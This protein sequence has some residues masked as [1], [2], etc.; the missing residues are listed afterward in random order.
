MLKIKGLLLVCFL[1]LVGSALAAC[2]SSQTDS[3]AS[4]SSSSGSSKEHYTFKLSEAQV[5]QY[6]TSVAEKAFAKE[7]SDKTN[8]RIQ[9]KVYTGGQLG[10]EKSSIEQTQS[11]VIAFGRANVG[12]MAQYAKKYGVFSFPF[13]FSSN[14]QLFDALN[15]NLG[16]ALAK[17]AEKANLVPLAYFDAGSRNFYTNK[18]IHSLS[19]LKGMKIR[20]MQNDILINSFKKLGVSPTPM[21]ASEVYSSLQTGVIDGAENNVNTYVASGAYE[22]SKYFTETG[23][24]RMPGVMFMNKDAWDKLSPGDQQII[25]QAAKDA[26]QTQRK[27]YAAYSQKSWDKVKAKGDVVTKVSPSMQKAFKAKVQPV[28]KQYESQYGDLFKMINQTK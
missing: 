12:P 23:H 21:S 27:D 13:L 16:K 17:N 28:Y 10:D 1:L 18:P 8:G 20:V 15:G 11:G 14:K 2:G 22:V 24:L 19:D 3:K 6:P 9:I 25:K 26:E 4:G 7:V 5:D